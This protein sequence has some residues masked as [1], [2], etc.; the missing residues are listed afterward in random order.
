VARVGGRRVAYRT[1]EE[2]PEG[3]K[4]LGRPRNRWK[5]NFE[6]DLQ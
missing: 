2:N 4:P 3:K 1:L 6:M 5:D